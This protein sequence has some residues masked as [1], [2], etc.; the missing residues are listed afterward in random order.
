M[1]PTDKG[2]QPSSP[3]VGFGENRGTLLKGSALVGAIGATGF[4]PT[5][6]GRLW[7]NYVDAVRNVE[8]GFPA[9]ILKT[10]RTSEMLSPLENYYKISANAPS[11]NY[12]EYLS[13][14]FGPNKNY[15]LT[16]TGAVFGE[17][18]NDVG[19]L[20]GYG[21]QIESGTNKGAAIADYYSRVS[22]QALD[23]HQSL[24]DS[25]LR[26]EWR[27][28]KTNLDFGSWLKTMAPFER[29]R[30]IILGA[31]LRNEVNLLGYSI[32]LNQQA[33]K[34]IAKFETLANYARAKAAADVGRLNTL[35]SAPLE[36][37]V[38][39]NLVSKIPGYKNMM[40]KPG[41][42]SQMIGRLAWKGA[43]VGLGFHGLEYVDYLRSKGS[44]MAPVLST[45]G[46]A[47]IGGLLLKSSLKPFSKTG[48]IAGALL[49]AAVGFAPRFDEG[50]LYGAASTYGDVSIAHAKVSEASGLSQSLRE[51]E[52]VTPGFATRSTA[53][54]M[55]LTGGLIAGFAGYSNLLKEAIFNKHP[56]EKFHQAI[57]RLREVKAEQTLAGFW[58]S[59]IGQKVEKLPVLGRLKNVKSKMALGFL[60]GVALWQAA[61][62]GLSLLSGNPMAA[63]PGAA[64]LGTTETPEHLQRIYSGQEEVAVRKG[65]WWEMGRCL[66][67][68]NTYELFD[69]KI[70]TSD[71]IKIGDIL[72]GRDFQPARVLNIY[73]RH[74]TGEIIKLSSAFDRDNT[75]GVTAEH[76][77]PI[78]RKAYGTKTEIKEVNA[79]EIKVGDFVEIPIKKYESSLDYISTLEFIKDPVVVMDGKVYSSQRNWYT[80]NLQRSGSYS[81]P[82]EIDLNHDIGFLFGIFLAEG[83]ISFNKEVP[84]FIEMVHSIKEKWI[85]DKIQY[86]TETYF[87][88]KTTVR[89]KGTGKKVK[90]GCYVTRIC[91]SILAKL[92]RYLFYP[93]K[94]NSLEKEIPSNFLIASK[95]FKKGLIVGYYAGDGHWDNTRVISSSRKWLLEQV[96]LIAYS[97]DLLSGIGPKEENDYLGRWKLRFVKENGNNSALIIYKNKIYAAIRSIEIEEYND[98]VYDF[99]VDHPDH[100]F[101]A[102]SFLVHNS[103]S[104]KGGRLDYY[105]EHAIA[106]LRSRAALKGT[107]GSEEERWEYDPVLHPLNA[108]FG[109]D[110][111]KY[112]YEQKYQ[113]ERPAPLTS[114]YFEDVP[115]VGPVLSATLGNLI[116]P[117]KLVR[118]SEWNLGNEEYSPEVDVTGKLTPAYE[119]G[120]QR[121]GAPVRPDETSQLL[122]ELN[123][124]RR[125]MIGLPG[126]MEGAITDA[127]IGREEF[128]P[129]LKTL[130]SMGKETGSEYWLWKHLNLGGGMASTESI[131]RF[132]PHTRNYLET[133][134]PL[135]NSLA[136]WIPDNY[137]MDLKTGNPYSKIAEAEIRL[138]GPGYASR[139]SELEG[140]DPE[141]YP[142][143]HRVKILGDIAMYSNGYRKTLSQAKRNF[144]QLS[145][146]HQALVRQT[147]LQ[148][149]EKKKRKEFDEYRFNSS[150]LRT[151]DVTVSKILSPTRFITEE[152]GNAIFEAE[153][154]GSILDKE[155]AMSFAEKSL[156]GKKVSVALPANE[157]QQWSRIVAG[158]RIKGVPF[159]DGQKYSTLLSESGYAQSEKLTAEFEQLDYSKNEQLAGALGEKLLHAMN[160]PLETLT[161][162][163]PASKFIRKR[164]AVEDYYM[165][166]ISTDNAFWD[167]P[168]E[169]FI[170]PTIDMVSFKTGARAIPE[171]TEQ[172]RDIEKYFDMLK[173]VKYSRLEAGARQ[174][175]DR[176]L[177]SKY[178]REKSSTLFGADAYKSPVTAMQ[179]I[180]RL[181][182]GYFD[183]FSKAQTPEERSAILELVPEEQKRIYTSQWARQAEQA[184]YARREAGIERKE[185]QQVIEAVALSRAAEGF[186][187]QKEDMK[188]WAN[189]TGGKID[190]DDWMRER[191]AEDYFESHSLPEIDSLFWN[192]AV[193]LDDVKMKYV[194]MIGSDAHDFDLWEQRRQSLELKPYIN[195]QLIQELMSS[196]AEYI[197]SWEAANNPRTLTRS[198]GDKDANIQYIQS[199]TAEGGIEYNIN[200]KDGRKKLIDKAYK[201]IGV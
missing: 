144:D 42:A 77:I 31:K 51:Q 50:I 181:E 40:V 95:D 103:S 138:P 55:G 186:N 43:L 58:S 153:G 130:E 178:L 118:A 86:I 20:L 185:D 125:E 32:K 196:K 59:R 128:L 73:T 99:E 164:S 191:K 105:R 56:G 146:E 192:P 74:H 62:T 89:F 165:S 177:A 17:V 14:V 167:R 23:V 97:I 28:S 142:L 200:V 92:F 193:D 12:K 169:N 140:V 158:P 54:G 67:K 139:F 166:R 152:Y 22:G 123:Y 117:R 88:T 19:E 47:A 38:I 6:K 66:I 184:A 124:R 106:R 126:F 113:Y 175:G 116:K 25:I 35:L 53:I 21:I 84:H 114:S 132:I 168:I 81:I 155:Q 149:R 162:L 134:N 78:L 154:I 13:T 163:S 87:Q 61:T 34:R 141:D 189:T 151:E 64:L 174:K 41:T 18:T 26:N 98:T 9:G 115:F 79:S 83:N 8:T 46:G 15:S 39:G 157:D 111:W 76:K 160:T 122:N 188:E 70:K 100:L 29:R 108:L 147:E 161:P 101:K 91:S 37:P 27:K 109:S 1:I 201:V 2:K 171:S 172:R 136:S 195:E 11:G 190:F 36:L 148:V 131:R 133:Y 197:D 120:G 170:K 183:E 72:I 119:L 48:M 71:Q 75:V 194:D 143:A 44:P 96:Q 24:N 63:I 82:L 4:I 145:P 137:F 80:G 199:S 33:A 30:R 49:G 3:G 52:D 104:Y 65:R 68:S 5:K 182:R 107:F 45:A 173:W 94:Y 159:V 180:P 129:N 93:E 112:H 135:K 179:A 150:L 156:L 60:G 85:V 69:G 121:E 102:G 187:F 198:H 90:E 176:D 10:L 110:D 127:L 16:R 57:E 7:N